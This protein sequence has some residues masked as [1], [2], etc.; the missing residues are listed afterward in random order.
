MTPKKS[1]KRKNHHT[2]SK[3]RLKSGKSYASTVHP[4]SIQALSTIGTVGID[5]RGCVQCWTRSGVAAH[6]GPGSKGRR[7]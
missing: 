3:N 1:V 5:D 6:L 2:E 7:T 4:P